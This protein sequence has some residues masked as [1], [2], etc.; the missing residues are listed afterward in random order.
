MEPVKR[1][2]DYL[3]QNSAFQPGEIATICS[4][5][6]EKHLSKEEELFAKGGR[7]PFIVFVA[8][9][10]LRSYI[11]SDEGEEIVKH[12]IC[13]DE[14]FAETDSFEKG[15]PC[16]FY[17]RAVT[18]CEILILS[19]TDSKF[20]SD[21]IPE[22]EIALKSGAMSAMNSMIRSQEFLRNGEAMDKYRF[23][24]ENF[25]ELAQQVP[26]KYIASWLQITQSS[27]SRIRKQFR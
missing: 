10:I 11:L 19:A 23:F 20:L 15:T 27:L 17:V 18:A 25:P 16:A 7:F 22:W 12:F 1:L 26:L 8:E 3:E 24:I 13:R 14:F 21:Q 5:F 6:Q 9:G 2:S 4:C